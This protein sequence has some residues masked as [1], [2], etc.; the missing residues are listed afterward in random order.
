MGLI[1]QQAID[2]GEGTKGEKR[3]VTVTVRKLSFPPIRVVGAVSTCNCVGPIGL[4]SA[5]WLYTTSMMTSMPAACIARTIILNSWTGLS[6]LFVASKLSCGRTVE[7]SRANVAGAIDGVPIPHVEL[8]TDQPALSLLCSQKASWEVT[9]DDFEGLGSGPA[10]ALVAREN[11]FRQIGYTDAFD[12]TA[13]AVETDDE[14]T[15]SAAEQVAELA[16]L[17]EKTTEET[18]TPATEG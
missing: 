16:E 2:T 14:P 8:T 13:L 3:T 11:E 18:E 6:V 5:V 1:L 7:S 17:Q 12:L 10:R 9:T 15:E 4:P